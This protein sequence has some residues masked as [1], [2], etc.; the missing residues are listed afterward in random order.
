MWKESHSQVLVQVQSAVSE[1]KYCQNKSAMGNHVPHSYESLQVVIS[2][3]F[4]KQVSLFCLKLC[5][6]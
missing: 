2:S 3:K 1:S 5:Y 6:Q 4:H